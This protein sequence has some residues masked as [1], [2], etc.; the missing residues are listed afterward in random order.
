M[1]RCT[2]SP[3][4]YT[5]L[6]FL[7][8]SCSLIDAFLPSQIFSTKAPSH[9]ARVEMVVDPIMFGAGLNFD[10]AVEV[11]IAVASAAAGAMTQIPR[12][13]QLERELETAKSALTT[14]ELELVEKIR[15]LEDKLFVMDQEFEEQTVK[16]QRQYDKTQKEQMEAF[17]EKVKSDMAFK[18]E[19]QIA[20][21]RSAKLLNQADN[22]NSRTLRQEEL[23]QLKLQQI[24][25]NDL[26]SKLEEAIKDSDEEI[27][28]LRAQVSRK[29]TFLFW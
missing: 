19:I 12:V 6:L 9:T 13:Q 26:N 16:F 5:V 17:K 25:L 7:I 8:A 3:S 1:T 18:L 14:S 4:V 27:T 24:R 20:Q 29:K 23:S 10:V 28:R 11:G 2:A 21:D 15:V 22:E